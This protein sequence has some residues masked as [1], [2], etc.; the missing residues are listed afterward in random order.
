MLKQHKVTVLTGSDAVGYD[1]GDYIID[2]AGEATITLPTQ[3]LGVWYRFIN[4]GA[5]DAIIDGTT[6]ATG[7]TVFI[8]SDGTAWRHSTG[9]GGGGAGTVTE[10]TGSGAI[11]VANGTTT[12]AV[13]HVDTTGY[14]HVPTGGSA[15]KFLGYSSDGTAVWDDPPAGTDAEVELDIIVNG[16]DGEIAAAL[17]EIVDG[18]T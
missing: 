4:I 8:V 16:G 18:S 13:S 10:V 12:P 17:A 3:S 14:K 7:E 15:G 11:S 1:I 6:I 5:G 2:S 9:G